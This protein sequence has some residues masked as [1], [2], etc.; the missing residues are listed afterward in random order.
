MADTGLISDKAMDWLKSVHYSEK[1]HDQRMTLIFA[2]A[3]RLGSLKDAVLQHGVTD[4]VLAHSV[5]NIDYLFPDA[6][7]VTPTPQFIDRDQA[8]VS[9]V[10]SKT[11]HTPF[12]RIKSSFANITADEARAKGYAKGKKKLDEVFTLLKRTT[13]PQTI[14]KKQTLDRD[15]ILDITDFDVVSWIRGEM[16]GKLDEEIARAI[17]VG[18]GRLS[19][20]DD[21]IQEARSRKPMF[22]LSG[23]MMICLPSRLRLWITLRRQKL[24]MSVF[25]QG[26]IIRVLETRSSSRPLQCL[27]R[28]SCPRIP[29]ATECTR[30]RLNWQLQCWSMTLLLFRL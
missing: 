14:Y 18:D 24:L 2:D 30:I 20:S 12:S 26:K 1:P 27:Q 19:S 25:L 16:R 6:K 9:V 13:T 15:D 28:C 3:K 8:W 29:R 4:D 22:G 23:P 21:K 17:L 11:H 7:N 5:T 10:M